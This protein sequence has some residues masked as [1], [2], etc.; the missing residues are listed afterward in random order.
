MTSQLRTL[1]GSDLL[2]LGTV[3]NITHIIEAN[4][5]LVWADSVKLEYP[6][7]IRT[8]DQPEFLLNHK[9]W[10]IAR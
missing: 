7:K 6:H 1:M 8:Q 5:F 10:S 2:V 4:F 3:F 9:A